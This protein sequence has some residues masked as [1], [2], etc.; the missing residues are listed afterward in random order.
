[1]AAPRPLDF[2]HAGGDIVWRGTDKPEAISVAQAEALR[3][4]FA[5]N[6]AAFYEAR[7]IREA[8]AATRSW[9]DLTNALDAREAYFRPI[10]AAHARGLS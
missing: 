7:E 10:R 8:R 9:R 5:A 6:A 1:M 2:W 4:E 3:D